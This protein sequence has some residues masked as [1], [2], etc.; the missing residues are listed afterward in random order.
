M[1]LLLHH[2][3]F[4]RLQVSKVIRKLER[5]FS[6]RKIVAQFLPTLALWIRVSMTP[7]HSPFKLRKFRTYHKGLLVFAQRRSDTTLAHDVSRVHRR[8]HLNPI[9][10]SVDQKKT[11]NRLLDFDLLD[12]VLNVFVD[13]SKMIDDRFR[14]E[15]RL[16][17]SESERKKKRRTDSC[18]HRRQSD[19]RKRRRMHW[20]QN[21]M[22]IVPIRSFRFFISLLRQQRSQLITTASNTRKDDEAVIIQLEA[23]FLFELD[24]IVRLVVEELERIRTHEECGCI[25]KLLP[26]EQLSNFWTRNQRNQIIEDLISNCEHV[27]GENAGINARL[28]RHNEERR[29]ERR[30][31]VCRTR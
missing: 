13:R 14:C 2:R 1:F 16:N 17:R 31:G 27:S 22:R 8:S 9:V 20:C 6:S 5:K 23:C 12:P 10:S 11:R 24:N 3:A 4:R 28:T 7:S 19:K 29:S 30:T 26:F 25:G 15:P 18:G 21:S